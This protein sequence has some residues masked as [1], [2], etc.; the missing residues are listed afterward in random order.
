MLNAIYI[1]DVQV[2]VEALKA[3]K[4]TVLAEAEAKVAALQAEK[5]TV[6]AEAAAPQAAGSGSADSD[7]KVDELSSQITQK[8]AEATSL[9]AQIAALQATY[10]EDV[11]KVQTMLA[12][13]TE[14][15]S[16]C[17]TCT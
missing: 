8:E 7:A 6:L 12:E 5:A 17:C 11:K 3:E 4:A 13:E 15:L 16:H 1:Y 9:N 2:A 10:E 14:V